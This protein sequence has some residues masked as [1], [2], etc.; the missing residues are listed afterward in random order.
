MCISLADHFDISGC[1]GTLHLGLHSLGSLI[2]DLSQDMNR[3][4][5]LAGS[6]LMEHCL[7]MGYKYINLNV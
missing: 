3:F 5:H 7:D 2:V 1:G 6:T 4:L